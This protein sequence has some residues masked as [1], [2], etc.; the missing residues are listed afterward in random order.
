MFT[1]II[2]TLQPIQKIKIQNSTLV[3]IVKKPREW[4]IKK[5]ESI[6]IDGVCSTIVHS[7][8]N[9]FSVTYMSETRQRTIVNIRRHGDMVN[10]ERSLQ[11]GG[12]LDGHFVY[13]HIDEVGRVVSVSAQASMRVLTIA[14]GSAYDYCLVDKGAIAINGV[15]LTVVKKGFG[16]HKLGVAIIPHTGHATNLRLLKKADPVNLE[17]DFLAKYLYKIYGQ[18][19]ATT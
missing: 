19:S 14:C 15:S 7:C 17:Y 9:S 16:R 13:G 18:T 6:S 1:G 8:Q 11:I 3:W 2:S 12:R 5:G 4:K 10:L